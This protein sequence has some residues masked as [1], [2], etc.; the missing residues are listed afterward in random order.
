ML[1]SL[2]LHGGFAVASHL[3]PASHVDRDAPM[4]IVQRELPKKNKP[5]K[6]EKKKVE[7]KEEE[8]KK[9]LPKKVEKK[10]APKKKRPNK[11]APPADPEPQGKPESKTPAA[12]DTG[13]KTFGLDMQGT[14]TAA[15]GTGVA[16][17]QGQ[18]LQQ[19]PRVRRIGKGRPDAKPG[20]KKDYKPGERAPL[21]VVTTRPKKLKDVQPRYPE[22]L[23][24]L[25]IEGR[26]VLKLTIDGNGKVVDAKVLKGL[27]KELDAE[28]IKAAKQLRF[29]PGKAGGVPIK[30]DITYTFTF[31]LD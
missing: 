4:E 22:H 3:L 9:E 11:P 29:S 5:K 26:V 10:I 12:P 30:M 17:P 31:V 6:L 21:A 16:I 7:K 18:T 8:A 28:A 14:T 1:L 19:D 27:H 2:L 13:A 20:F 25:E 23:R 24:D 15:P